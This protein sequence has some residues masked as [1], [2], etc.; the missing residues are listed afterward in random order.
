MNWLG[1]LLKRASA[2]IAEDAA[3]YDAIVKAW[4]DVVKVDVQSGEPL[5]PLEDAIETVFAGAHNEILKTFGTVEHFKLW[6]AVEK[7]LGLRTAE[8]AATPGLGE[9]LTVEPVGNQG[10]NGQ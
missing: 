1:K 7:E 2:P 6:T 9:S 3:K 5:L 8:T 4:F 10:A